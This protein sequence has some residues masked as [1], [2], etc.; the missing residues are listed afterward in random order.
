M[1]LYD[2]K[3]WCFYNW[4]C[5]AA[6][7]LYV[8]LFKIDDLR[9]A[10]FCIPFFFRISEPRYLHAEYRPI[11]I[12]RSK[13]ACRQRNFWSNTYTMYC[14]S[15]TMSVTFVEY[16][17]CMKPWEYFFFPLSFSWYFSNS[18][19]LMISS[20]ML[21]CADGCTLKRRGYCKAAIVAGVT[22]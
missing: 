15:A 16:Y 5:R 1:R 7:S 18:S 4:K 13:D 10:R 17:L 2:S 3:K 12:D 21:Q 11:T 8:F 9:I 20:L 14:L 22:C 19:K 6:I